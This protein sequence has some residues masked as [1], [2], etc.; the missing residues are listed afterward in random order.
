MRRPRLW[1]EYQSPAATTLQS[2]G[3][4]WGQRIAHP[5]L[6][7]LHGGDR[8]QLSWFF[9]NAQQFLRT[10]NTVAASVSCPPY[11]ALLLKPLDRPLSRRKRDAQSA[12]SACSSDKRV[13]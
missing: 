3:R 10:V 5:P 8:F 12:R 9:E 4:S 1:A 6:V 7:A 11:Y 13:G 2:S